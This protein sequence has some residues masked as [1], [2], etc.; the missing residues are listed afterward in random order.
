M[1]NIKGYVALF[2]SAIIVVVF[3][4]ENSWAE[5][6]HSVDVWDYIDKWQFSETT[7]LFHDSA[8]NLYSVD[9]NLCL[10]NK[11]NSA[12]DLL[13]RFG[14]CGTGNGQFS[15]PNGVAV[16]GYGYIY[17][18]D[19]YNFRIQ[20]FDDQGRFV[21]SWSMPKTTQG[22]D[23]RP[24]DI[25]VDAANNIYVAGDILSK[26]CKFS[27]NGLLLQTFG[28]GYGSG[29]GE[30]VSPH[31]VCVAPNGDVYV[32]DGSSSGSILRFDK[33]GGFISRFGDDDT[34]PGYIGMGSPRGMC[35]M[36][37]SLLV[38]LSGV[39]YRY[40]FDGVFIESLG[41]GGFDEHQFWN[42]NDVSVGPNGTLA[43]G[44]RQTW[45]QLFTT[46]PWT[47][48]A[49]WSS[50]SSE[51]G[52]FDG[53]QDFAFG[54]QGNV[55]V[56]DSGNDRIQIFSMEGTYLDSWG[57]S[58]TAYGKFNLPYSLDVDELGNV[59]VSDF[60]NY[61]IQKFDA[62]GN[63]I[64]AWGSQGSGYIQFQGACRLRFGPDGNLYALE[65]DNHRVQIFS[66]N[67]D[68]VNMWGTPGSQQG[69]LTWPTALAID[70]QGYLYISDHYK[71]IQ[72]FT[73]QGLFVDQFGGDYQDPT[74]E[75]IEDITFD[76]KGNLLA[77]NVHLQKVLTVH[78]SNGSVLSS[79][80]E[81]GIQKGQFFWVTSIR[82][83]P[84]WNF[85][86]GDVGA[87]R[88]QIFR[89]IAV[90]PGLLNILILQD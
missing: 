1:R 33:N 38:T 53:P 62:N 20:K 51:T 56:V 77:L 46:S 15:Y 27:P 60:W 86:T 32:S 6:Y 34:L 11:Y 43:A 39:V 8:G 12:G 81:K 29:P 54:P 59:Y 23:G 5:R 2:I 64:K 19:T 68:F 50:A 75:R 21:Q 40:A 67:G 84:G 22:N 55:Y 90:V 66:K 14:S 41:E 73:A 82:A 3:M 80:G 63:F 45:I 42:L 25:A 79:F 85:F 35:L 13:L 88:V 57:G 52:L 58:G 28:I 37:N 10:V 4:A 36:G 49:A 78:P 26:V 17:V 65:R 69:E 76:Q 83:A 9:I 18:S 74:F 16:D 48:V 87:N 71:R 61:R 72:K 70:A 89:S 47:F 30:M 44:S 24:Y 31:G 7:S